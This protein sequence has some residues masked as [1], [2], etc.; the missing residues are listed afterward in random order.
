MIEKLE[1]IRGYNE[2]GT[3]AWEVPCDE[4]SMMDKI[5]ELVEAVNRME[6]QI[7]KLQVL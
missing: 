6:R 1:P 7:E 5:N 3:L 4:W 2:D